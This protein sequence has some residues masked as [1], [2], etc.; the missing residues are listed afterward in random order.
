MHA[1]VPDKSGLVIGG[2]FEHFLADGI[3]QS[4]NIFFAGFKKI[5]DSYITFLLA[6]FYNSSID[7]F[8][9]PTR[10]YKNVYAKFQSYFFPS[11]KIRAFLAIRRIPFFCFLSSL[12]E[13][14]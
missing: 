2:M 10:Y 4:P 5:I 13:R 3:S 9:R 7:V 6:L 12:A 14:Y 1:A 11:S 8:I